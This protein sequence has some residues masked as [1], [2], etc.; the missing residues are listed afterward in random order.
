MFHSSQ[1]AVSALALMAEVQRLDDGEGPGAGSDLFP[2]D[3]GLFP[4]VS[5]VLEPPI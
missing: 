4:F 2:L 1:N 3:N 5:L